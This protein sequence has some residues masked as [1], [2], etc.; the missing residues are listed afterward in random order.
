[1]KVKYELGWELSKTWP[2]KSIGQLKRLFRKQHSYKYRGAFR[3]HSPLSL[4]LNPIQFVDPNDPFAVDLWV[5]LYGQLSLSRSNR[6]YVLVECNRHNISIG[7][8]TAKLQMQVYPG[9]VGQK[10]KFIW[11]GTAQ[12]EGNFFDEKSI[13]KQLKQSILESE[14]YAS[15]N[16]EADIVEFDEPT[17]TPTLL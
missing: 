5:A 4:S 17:A 14:Y 6:Y 15:E 10:G 16:T 1:M 8:H 13:R 7:T 2:T 3:S 9:R 11:L 12:F